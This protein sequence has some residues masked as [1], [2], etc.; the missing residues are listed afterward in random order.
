MF[1]SE[2]IR[3]ADI[4]RPPAP[5]PAAIAASVKRTAKHQALAEEIERLSSERAETIDSMRRLI[6][7]N[8]RELNDKE[9]RRAEEKRKGIEEL[10]N[11]LLREIRPHRAEHASRVAGALRGMVKG[12]ALRMISA[13]AEFNEAVTL[14]NS[15]QSEVERV[16]GEPSFISLPRDIG[17]LEHHARSLVGLGE[18]EP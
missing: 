8:S 1:R 13:L 9:I 17:T 14:I 5:S 3:D 2:K 12:A 15:A 7:T 10:L 18:Q 4:G 6:A 11:A 16:G